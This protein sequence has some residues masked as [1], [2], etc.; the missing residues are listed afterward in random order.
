M[1]EIQKQF[2]LRAKS[3]FEFQQDDLYFTAELKS[4]ASGT[5]TVDWLASGV[6]PEGNLRCFLTARVSCAAMNETDAQTQIQLMLPAIVS[7]SKLAQ[8]SGGL[9]QASRNEIAVQ[10]IEQ[11][12]AIHL[13][14][15]LANLEVAGLIR[16]AAAKT[17][18]ET[19][20]CK[21]VGLTKYVDFLARFEGVP[22]TTIRRR[23]DNA[24]TLGLVPK[25]VESDD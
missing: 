1:N 6:D 7:L 19:A 23:L 17:A 10:G 24:R 4:R 21:S 16:T 12:I 15:H 25:R 20:F 5:M 18:I 3:D 2:L 9:T 22:V 14:K 13:T 8:T 11:T